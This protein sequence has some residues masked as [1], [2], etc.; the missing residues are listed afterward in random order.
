MLNKK[1]PSGLTPLE[2][3]RGVLPSPE[4]SELAQY[5]Q[6]EHNCR[7]YQNHEACVNAASEKDDLIAKGID[8]N[9]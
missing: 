6:D 4:E 1:T 8:V 2:I 5:K 3:L 7:T 9:K